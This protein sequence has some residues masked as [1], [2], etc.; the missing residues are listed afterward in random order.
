MTHVSSVDAPHVHTHGRVRPGVTSYAVDKVVAALRHAPAPVVSTWLT[1]DAA[2]PGN[3][4][5]ADVNINGVHLHVHAVG[6]SLHEATDLMQERLRSRLR[7]IRRRPAQGPPAPQL[8]DAAEEQRPVPAA[9]GPG[10]TSPETRVQ[11][12]PPEHAGHRARRPTP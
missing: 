9:V 5:D 11:A 1:I 10:E 2:A 8:P 12:Q 6:E 7:R 3:R 4:I